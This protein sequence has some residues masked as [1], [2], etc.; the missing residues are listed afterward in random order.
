M[1]EQAIREEKVSNHKIYKKLFPPIVCVY[2]GYIIDDHHDSS[3]TECEHCL[4][5]ENA[6]KA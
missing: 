4:N 2:C 1:I 5:K 6:D 3:M